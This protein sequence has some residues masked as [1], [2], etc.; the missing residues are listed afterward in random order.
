MTL[1]WENKE[2]EA[3]DC[4]ETPTVGELGGP[5]VALKTASRPRVAE[6]GTRSRGLWG[7][8]PRTPLPLIAR[9]SLAHRTPAGTRPE[10][11]W[12]DAGRALNTASLLPKPISGDFVVGW[13]EGLC[14][15][16]PPSPQPTLPGLGL[17][18]EFIHSS[19]HYAA[20]HSP[21]FSSTFLEHLL[22]D[23]CWAQE[24]TEDPGTWPPG[25]PGL[26]GDK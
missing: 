3:D 5:A 25:T 20:S 7:H 19:T 11:R 23:S 9:G 14:G 15:P 24:D 18:L 21:V 6:D 8:P 26:V 2:V 17:P 12:T 1:T 10:G 4:R 22:C 13:E 16:Q